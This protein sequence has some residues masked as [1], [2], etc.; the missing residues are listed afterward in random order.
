MLTEAKHT[1]S[2]NKKVLIIHTPNEKIAKF[3]EKTKL[4]DEYNPISIEV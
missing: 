3:M 2:E 1:L 4:L